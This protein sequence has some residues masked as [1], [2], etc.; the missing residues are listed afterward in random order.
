MIFEGPWGLALIIV[1]AALVSDVW[2]LMGALLASRI[3]EGS[4]VF[5]Y[6]K[7][8]ATTLIAAVIIRLTLY[9]TGELAQTTMWLRLGALASGFAVY[10]IARRSVALGLLVAEIVL[11]IGAAWMGPIAIAQP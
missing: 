11:I 10:L 2:R 9:P 7:A 5:R 6:V 1:A 4:L 8:V 3:D